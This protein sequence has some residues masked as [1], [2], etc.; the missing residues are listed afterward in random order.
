MYIIDGAGLLVYMGAIDDRPTA[1]H[2]SVKGARNYVREA[3]E[4]MAAGR[5]VALA[6]TL[7]M[8]G[9]L[10]FEHPVGFSAAL[11]TRFLDD[12]P[13]IEDRS[14]TARGY[15]LLD[16]LLRYRWRN[17]QATFNFY[18]LTNTDWREAQFS[19][20]SCVRGEIGRVAGCARSC[21]VSAMP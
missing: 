17:V 11:R 13:G 12:R 15:T 9:G 18:N 8:N 3:L 5:P 14:L 2:A 10:T 1:S 21:R 6:P 16:L 20:T 4:A 19:D 7:L